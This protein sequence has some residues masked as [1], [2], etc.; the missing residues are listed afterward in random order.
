MW[1]V[2]RASRRTLPM[3]IVALRDRVLDRPQSR[4]ADDEDA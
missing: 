3:V 4:L 1:A 2:N